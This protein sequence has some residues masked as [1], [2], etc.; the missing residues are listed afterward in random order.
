MLPT[1]TRK[2]DTSRG[3]HC[4]LTTRIT[5]IP[6]QRCILFTSKLALIPIFLL[7]RK[8]DSCYQYTRFPSKSL[9]TPNCHQSTDPPAPP[10]SP[11]VLL[12]YLGT[13]HRSRFSRWSASSLLSRCCDTRP[14]QIPTAP[15]PQTTPPPPPH[16]SQLKSAPIQPT[17]NMAQ[18]PLTI[19][20][21][22]YLSLHLSSALSPWHGASSGCGGQQ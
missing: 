4:A 11:A 8:K 12:H 18:F 21:K 5:F 22:M 1:S 13:Q 20:R 3:A 7:R 16:R 19:Q 14:P 2:S 17:A 15:R 6:H 9:V 10:L